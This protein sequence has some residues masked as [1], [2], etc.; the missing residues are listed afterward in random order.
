MATFGLD[1]ET[2][3]SL[4]GYFKSNKDYYECKFT[5]LTSWCKRDCLDTY[6]KNRADNCGKAL[7]SVTDEEFL[8]VYSYMGT[9]EEAPLALHS[10]SR[11]NANYYS[12]KIKC[13]WSNKPCKAGC[14]DT[15]NTQ[16]AD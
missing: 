8:D 2:P 11:A 7:L 5:C 12:C 13:G 6:Y 16:I 4:H 9:E 10:W 14:L 1:E 15:Y 3:L